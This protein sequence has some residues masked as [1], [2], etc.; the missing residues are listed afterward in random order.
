MRRKGVIRVGDRVTIN[1]PRVVERVGYPLSY[2]DAY[3]LAAT[4]PRYSQIARIIEGGPQ[5][6]VGLQGLWLETKLDHR[7][8]VKLRSLLAYQILQEKGFGG[9][10]RQ[11]YY[12]DL[13]M[14]ERG[15]V[16]RDKNA[17]EVLGKRVV[18]TGLYNRPSSGYD[19]YSG[20]HWYDPGFLDGEQ[21][22]ILIR[23]ELGEFNKADV[24]KVGD[25]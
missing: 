1:V 14:F 22:H 23:T 8:D 17:L 12:R 7:V 9:K 18:K 15:M 4:D 6:V 21:T 24:T 13:S 2:Y 20:E 3:D 16:A 5:Q 10:E 19:S 25:D 11:I